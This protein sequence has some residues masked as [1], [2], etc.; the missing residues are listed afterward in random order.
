MI[1]DVEK[2]LAA[3]HNELRALKVHSGLV[4]SQLLLPENSPVQS[5]SGKVS[6]SGSGTGPVGRIRFRFSR[7]DGVL[8]PPLVDFASEV[9]ISPTYQQYA[10]D[11][12]FTFYANDLSYLTPLETDVYIGELGDGFVDFYVDFDRYLQTAF[13]SL[14]SLDVKVTVQAMANVKGTLSV[15][16]VI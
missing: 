10:E 6:L 9:E 8:D 1:Y 2:R 11:N 13:F 4:Y 5:Y 12:G 3:V 7:S 14:N 16:K 15:E